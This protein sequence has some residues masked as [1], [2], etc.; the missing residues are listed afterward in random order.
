MFSVKIFELIFY[1]FAKSL[2]FFFF[3][4]NIVRKIV[5]NGGF[6]DSELAGEGWTDRVG[7]QGARVV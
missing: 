6:C 1:C 3:W 4:G 7:V 2:N 5:E